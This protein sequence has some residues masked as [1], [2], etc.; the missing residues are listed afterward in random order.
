MSETCPHC[1][2]ELP[3]THDAFCPNCRNALDEPPATPNAPE[4]WRADGGARTTFAL[5]VIGWFLIVA[6]MVAS[7]TPKQGPHGLPEDLVD[8]SFFVIGIVLLVVA[9]RRSVRAKAARRQG[10]PAPADHR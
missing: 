6:A 5:K 3:A 1:G 8:I 4:R 2:A 9:F 10:G 7:A